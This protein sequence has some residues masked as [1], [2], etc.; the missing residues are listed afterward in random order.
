MESPE[1]WSLSLLE[2]EQFLELSSIRFQDIINRL[3]NK[4]RDQ[5]MEIMKL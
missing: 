2:Q 4:G 1:F 5:D 3:E